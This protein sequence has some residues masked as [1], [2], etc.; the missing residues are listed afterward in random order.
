[1]PT[2]SNTE[3]IRA[4][5]KQG[6]AYSEVHSI[7]GYPKSEISRQ[8]GVLR[9]MGFE[10]RK[11]TDEE[12][13]RHLIKSMPKGSMSDVLNELSLEQIQ[14]LMQKSLTSWADAIANEL[15]K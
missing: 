2:R 3:E 10:P 15:D 9:E 6:Y 13:K 5:L 11:R 1:M 7:T 8:G 14:K 12:E 4:L